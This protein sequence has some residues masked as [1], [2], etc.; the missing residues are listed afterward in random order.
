MLNVTVLPFYGMF[1]MKRLVTFYDAA[2][3]KWTAVDPVN[4]VL[5]HPI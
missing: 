2:V 5:R 3:S 4:Y 1:A